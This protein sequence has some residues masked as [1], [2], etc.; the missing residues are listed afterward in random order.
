MATPK[1]YLITGASRGIGK[2]FAK[3]LLQRP[4]TTVIAAVRDPSHSA[5][6]ELSALDRAH[7]SR[8]LLVP[9][10]SS[11]TTSAQE[12][13]RIL[14]EDH[15]IKH[16]DVVIANAGIA[17]DNGPVRTTT[18]ENVIKHVL[19]NAIGPVVLFQA[20]A[21]LLQGSPT[22]QPVFVA[23]SSLMGSIGSMEAIAELPNT[24]S[25]Y[26]S[27]KAALNWFVRRIHFEEPWLT[28]FVLH[29]GTVETDMLVAATAGSGLQPEDMGAI[30]VQT[31]I[32]GMLAVIESTTRKSSGTFRAYDGSALPW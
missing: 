1:T 18:A 8:L 29:P 31:S 32:S 2:G 16:I 27:S 7:G 19:V 10:D 14:K 30:S 25:P 12:A 28:T 26:G 24:H 5:A 13:V 17:T 23:T 22:G 21:D 11:E 3:S 9:L 15:N 4:S 20:T 6:R